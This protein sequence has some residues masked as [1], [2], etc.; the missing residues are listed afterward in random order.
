MG[1]VCS[2]PSF[3]NVKSYTALAMKY[4]PRRR[5]ERIAFPKPSGRPDQVALHALA[6][7]RQLAVGCPEVQG[8]VQGRGKPPLAYCAGEH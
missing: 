5:G 4:E 6:R 1:S 2:R 8:G 3:V 7:G